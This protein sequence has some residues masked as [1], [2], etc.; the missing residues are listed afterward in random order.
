MGGCP[1]PRLPQA[2]PFRGPTQPRVPCQ[3][4]TGQGPGPPARCSGLLRMPV[5][6][7]CCPSP[8]LF[9]AAFL[10]GKREACLPLTSLSRHLPPQGAAANSWMITGCCDSTRPS[11]G[12]KRLPIPRWLHSGKW[13]D[14][15]LIRERRPRCCQE[16]STVWLCWQINGGK[17]FHKQ[18]SSPLSAETSEHPRPANG[19]A[20]K[21]R[22]ASAPLGGGPGWPCARAPGCGSAL[23]RP[24]GCVGRSRCFSVLLP[25]PLGFE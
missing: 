5:C 3:D 20:S 6:P 25:P 1:L 4:P 15:K 8:H 9:P 16:H 11:S 17:Q 12:L 22:R 10:Q 13:S 21:R 19:S 14:Q 18:K 24:A 2:A 7:S 23:L